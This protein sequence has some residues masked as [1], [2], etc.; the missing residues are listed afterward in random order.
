MR[1][2][3]EEL[4]AYPPPGAVQEKPQ[5]EFV[6]AAGSVVARHRLAPAGAG[7]ATRAAAVAVARGSSLRAR[8]HAVG[9][10]RRRCHDT[11]AA[12]TQGERWKR[13]HEH[14]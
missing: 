5:I 14:L 10:V 13:C 2:E 4:S 12:R 3:I 1:Q 8:P 6:F 7:G 11:F 9:S